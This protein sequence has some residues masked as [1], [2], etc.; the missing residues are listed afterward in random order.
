MATAI[1][2]PLEQYLE[3]SYRPDREYLDGDVVE[4]NVGKWE[5]ARV[6]ALL[7][8]MFVA[9]ESELNVYAATE[10]RSRVSATRVRIPDIVLVEAGPQPDVLERPPLLVVEILS[11]DDTY[12]DTVARAAD[13]RHMGVHTIWIVDPQSRTGRVCVDDVWRGA[14]VLEVPGTPIRV[15]LARLFARLDGISSL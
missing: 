15:D 8:S 11:P 7:T 2:I 5:H 4:R 14:S 13:Y 9:Y 3:T 10:W 6:Q 1:Q 12:A